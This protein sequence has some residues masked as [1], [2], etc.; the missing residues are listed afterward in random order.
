MTSASPTATRKFNVELIKPSRYDEDGYVIQWRIAYIPSNSLAAVDALVQNVADV[1]PLGKEV[2][3]EVRS[4]DECHT[5]IPVKEIIRRI[6]A[7]DGIVFLVGVQ[8]NQFP[9]AVDLAREFI[10]AGVRVVIGGFHISGCLSMLDE[11]P[12]DIVE[13][14]ELGITLFAGEAEGRME[15]LL[16]DALNDELKPLYNYLSDLPNLDGQVVPYLDPSIVERYQ[17]NF[18]SFDAGRGCPFQCSFCTIIN[19][20]GRKSRHRTADDIEEII[21]RNVGLNRRRYFITDDDFARN[22]NWEPILDRII[23][24]REEEGIKIKFTLQVD[25]QAHRIKNFVEK[26]RRAGCN[27]VFLG[28]EN[29][30]P[31]NLIA[32]N[33]RQN[34]ISDYREMLLKWRKHNVFTYA[35]YILG[36]P[37]DTPESIERDI[38]TIKRELPIDCLEFFVLTPLPGS[39]DH[40]ALYESGVELDPDMNKYDL[41]HVTTVHPKMSR[42]EL[43]DIYDRAWDLY[44]TPEHVETLMRR[45]EVSGGKARRIS[46]MVMQFWGS[47]HFEGVHPLQSGLFRKKVRLSRRYGL[48]KENPIIFYP[49]RLWEMLSTYVPAAWHYFKL[50]QQQRRI[51]A[52]P[53]KLEYTDEA[54]TP[55]QTDEHSQEDPLHQKATN[56][57]AEFLTENA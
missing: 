42:E 16:Q 23:K 38:E 25:T 5:V 36:F 39:A 26:A 8:T 35:G 11:I 13:A 53:N 14:Q 33:K 15:D 40:K 17:K 19:V 27:R 45:S 32:A 43:S 30:N 34:K 31:E 49:R 3:L 21:R 48:P 37:A 54:L 44:Y 2:D 24:L 4:F 29:V 18:V 1:L 6:K 22:T 20:Q 56:E 41:E 7:D 46:R 51:H 50:D 52:D 47:N 28:L 12:V 10:A 55:S 57:R 9:R